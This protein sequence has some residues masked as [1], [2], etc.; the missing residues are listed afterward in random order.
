MSE[1]FVSVIMPALNE[2]KSVESA[3]R[4]VL[5]QQGVRLEV[6]VVNGLSTDRTADIVRSLAGEDDRVRLL[7]NPQSIIPTGLNVGLHEARGTYIARVDCHATVSPDYLRRGA[8][9]LAAD[10]GLAAVGG[11]RRGV[12]P[13]RAG[14]SVALALSSR[15]GVGNSI[16]HY[17]TEYQETDHAS[18]GVYRADLARAIGGWDASLLVNEDADFDYRLRERGARIGFDPEMIIDW[19][20]RDSVGGLFRQYRRYGRGKAAMVRKNGPSAV[21]LR[22]LAA[23]AAVVGT[24]TLAVVGVARPVALLGMLPYAG[25]LSYASYLAWRRRPQ[26][27]DVSVPAIP[28]SFVAMHGGW[29]LGFL[30]DRKSV[31]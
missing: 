27:E 7:D 16:N 8:E 13:T 23:P 2:E 24:G 9:R 31:V 11:L 29:G 22:H 10:P 21:R 6:L 30:E 14:R 17:A 28:A 3:V 1:P 19:Q 4:S 12:S 26:S 15:F 5:R 20:V 18:F 25:A